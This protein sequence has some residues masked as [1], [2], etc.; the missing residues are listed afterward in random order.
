MSKFGELMDSEIPILILF[1]DKWEETELSNTIY[2]ITE[3]ASV[4]GNKAKVIKI[5]TDI[6]K[7]I[8]KALKIKTNPTYIVYKSGDMKWRQSGKVSTKELTEKLQE[9]ID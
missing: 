7:K 9:F 8:A 6:N 3:V 1:H 2:S 5:D 4:L